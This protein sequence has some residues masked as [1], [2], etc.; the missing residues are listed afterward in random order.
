MKVKPFY[1]IALILFLAVF[2]LS[3]CTMFGGGDPKPD[4]SLTPEQALSAKLQAASP[5]YAGYLALKIKQLEVQRTAKATFSQ[6]LDGDGKVT[7]QEFNLPPVMIPIDQ[8]RPHPAWALAG[9]FLGVSPHWLNTIYGYKNNKVM[10]ENLRNLAG[11]TT[12]TDVGNT[13]ISSSIS[14][15]AGAGAYASG[16]PITV[17]DQ[18][19]HNPA[20]RFDPYFDGGGTYGLDQSTQTQE[21]IS[22]TSEPWL[23]FL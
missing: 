4:L 2:L 7:K 23:D 18:G 5:D 17:G 20:Y 19:S 1:Q 21:T 13:K 12:W 6:E 8:K 22:Q 16:A 11:N 10:W 14:G 15:G 9:Q 3:G